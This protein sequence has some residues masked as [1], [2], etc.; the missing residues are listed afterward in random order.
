M[1]LNPTLPADLVIWSFSVFTFSWS[2]SFECISVK[3]LWRNKELSAFLLHNFFCTGR[4]ETYIGLL[5]FVFM[6]FVFFLEFCESAFIFNHLCRVD[7]YF[8]ENSLRIFISLRLMNTRISNTLLKGVE[9]RLII[10]GG[11]Q[12]CVCMYPTCLF[13]I[14]CTKNKV[15]H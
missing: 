11:K 2:Y 1:G 4:V 6:R 12:K 15:I 10:A 9:I 3:E 5:A 13:Y 7:S 8:V 14:H